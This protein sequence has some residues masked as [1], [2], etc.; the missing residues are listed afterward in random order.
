M[1]MR[2]RQQLVI[3]RQTG[4][5]TLTTVAVD[6]D[7]DFTQRARELKESLPDIGPAQARLATAVC[8]GCGTRRALDFDNPELPHGWAATEAGDFCPRCQTLN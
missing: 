2:Q 4:D 6:D 7:T 8:D 1:A 5:A 3:S